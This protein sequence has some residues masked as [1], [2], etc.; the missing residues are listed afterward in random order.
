MFDKVFRRMC[1]QP[2][3]FWLYVFAAIGLGLA[4]CASSVQL[5]AR[6]RIEQDRAALV[7]CLAASPNGCAGQAE[8]LRAD[9]RTYEAGIAAGAGTG[10]AFDDFNAGFAKGAANTSNVNLRVVP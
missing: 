7:S 5:E 4:G 2:I 1:A 9:E 10:N 8:L 3:G 6:Q